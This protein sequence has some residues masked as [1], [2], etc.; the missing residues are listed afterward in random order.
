MF[1]QFLKKKTARDIIQLK[2][3]LAAK[4]E[5]RNPEDLEPKV[6]SNHIGSFI[7][8]LCKAD[9]GFLVLIMSCDP[10]SQ[11]RTVLKYNA[12]YTRARF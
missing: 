9:G 1:R 11:A 3:Y 4:G 7:R 5:T 6:L 12:Q 10:R 8:G 2:K